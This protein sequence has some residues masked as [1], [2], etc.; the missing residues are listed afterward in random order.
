MANYDKKTFLL[1]LKTGAVTLQIRDVNGKLRHTIVGCTHSNTYV[2]PGSHTV[3]VQM[4]SESNSIKLDFCSDLE[5]RSAMTR[6]K[7]SLEIICQ[8]AKDSNSPILG[9]S[10]GSGGGT[11]PGSIV[12]GGLST[13]YINPTQISVDP[14]ADGEERPEVIL[15]GADF[16]NEVLSVDIVSVNGVE[17]VPTDWEFTTPFTGIQLRIF[18]PYEIEWDDELI[19]TYLAPEPD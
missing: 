17:L 18:P 9:G 15:T 7:N 19:I 8:N 12:A 1:P 6:L 10:G 16:P 3:T 11:P 13:L 2:T 4:K 14:F 5:A